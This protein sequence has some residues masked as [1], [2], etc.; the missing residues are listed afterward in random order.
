MCE[1]AF[2]KVKKRLSTPLV[3][4]KLKDGEPLLVYLAVTDEAISATIAQGTTDQKHVYFV[5]RVLQSPET[6]YQTI[7]KV[8]LVLVHTSW[9]LGHYFQSHQMIVKT[10]FPISKVL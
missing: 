8:A 6:H 5:S 1:A 10:D 4:R 7:E 2:T 3:L 9:R